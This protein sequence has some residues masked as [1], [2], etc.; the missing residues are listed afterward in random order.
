MDYYQLLRE[1]ESRRFKPLYF[2]HGDESYFIDQLTDFFEHKVL[3]E[4]EKGF[5]LSILYGLDTNVEQLISTAKRYPMMSEYQVVILKEAQKMRGLEK[6][7]SY[8]E[9]PVPTTILVICYK[10]KKLDK[11]TKLANNLKKNG[12]VFESK[13]LYENKVPQWIEHYLKDKQYR[14]KPNA[15]A[16]LAEYL[17]TDLSKI[18]NAL[19]K[20][21][22]NLPE[23]AEIGLQDIEKNIGI[24]RDYNV[25]ELNNAIGAKDQVKTFRIV[26]YFDSNPKSNPFVVTVGTL[27]S[28]FSKIYTYHTLKD[29][30]R[31][32]VA[33]SLRV[34][35]F[36]V[37]DYETAA[38]NYSLPKVQDVICLLHEYDLRSKGIHNV[39]VGEGDLLKE[40][41]YKILN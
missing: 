32:S 20:L 21:M 17:G 5:N 2:L 26:Q 13:K 28:F 15:C 24:N 34:N 19:D 9:R 11:R 18:V 29:K 23:N 33:S 12:V 37:K 16:L 35:P 10:N 1:L 4:T 3:N 22:I 7:A 41:V 6:L 27:Y 31:Q 39:N 8:T 40:L 38:R 14:I 36:F 25:F 30:S